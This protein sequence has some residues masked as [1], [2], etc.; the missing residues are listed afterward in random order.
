[1]ADLKRLIKLIPTVYNTRLLIGLAPGALLLPVFFSIIGA[2]PAAFLIGALA[3]ALCK[4]LLMNT[5]QQVEFSGMVCSS[6][7]HKSLMT[8]AFPGLILLMELCVFTVLFTTVL[9]A[10][11]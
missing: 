1:M 10:S 6:P 11:R 2:E 9:F 4:T 7:Y 8:R 5:I 3:G